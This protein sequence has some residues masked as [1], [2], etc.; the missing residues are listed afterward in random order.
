MLG[1]PGTSD[2]HALHKMTMTV[3]VHFESDTRASLH[4]SQSSNE[5]FIN[6]SLNLVS[7]R[8]LTA[9]LLLP[10]ANTENKNTP[11]STSS[12]VMSYKTVKS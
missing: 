4:V 2:N 7:V 3:M 11:I 8:S 5:H 9:Q 10:W 6:V 12:M 1:I